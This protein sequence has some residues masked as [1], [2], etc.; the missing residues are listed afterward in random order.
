M[1]LARCP[2]NAS[3]KY[4][5]FCLHLL[6]FQKLLKQLQYVAIELMMMIIMKHVNPFFKKNVATELIKLIIMKH[7]NLF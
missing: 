5:Y 7:V 2:V 3:T 6:S 4:S 1:L